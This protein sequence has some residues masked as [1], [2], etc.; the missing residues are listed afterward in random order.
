MGNLVALGAKVG[1][2][3]DEEGTFYM[4]LSNSVATRLHKMNTSKQSMPWP[5]F[6]KCCSHFSGRKYTNR[7]LDETHAVDVPK[8]GARGDTYS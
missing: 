7:F 1:R 8:H 6:L 3:D 4:V 5:L 2:S